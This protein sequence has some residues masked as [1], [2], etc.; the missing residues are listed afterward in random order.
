MPAPEQKAIPS[1]GTVVPSGS[2]IAPSGSQGAMGP[3]G[4]MGPTG[5]V[6]PPGPTRVSA[7]SGNMAKLGSDNL[8][9]VPQ[10]SLIPLSKYFGADTGSGTAYTVSVNSD[11]QLVQGVLVH[12]I[13]ANSSGSAPTLNVN[14]SGAIPL[15]SRGNV[16]LGVNELVANKLFTVMYDG[17]S[18]R[19]LTSLTR[20]LS[21]ANAGNITLDCAGFDAVVLNQSFTANTSSGMTLQH[22]AP[23]TPVRVWLSNTYTAALSW[24][25]NWTD[26][27]GNTGLTTQ[28]IWSSSL[29]AANTATKIDSTNAQS[30]IANNNILLVG[31]VTGGQ[32]IFL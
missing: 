2:L 8:I 16:A 13:P 30:I 3:T 21:V 22:L 28:W 11:F 6:G 31:G 7:D 20:Y 18:W 23:G 17:V 14:G 5:P 12:V 10:A 15:V 29:T 1:P 19:V 4:T 25:L 32:L 24:W 27:L 26:Q 9:S